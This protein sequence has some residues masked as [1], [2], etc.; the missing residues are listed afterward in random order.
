[1]VPG[2]TWVCS[3]NLGLRP[4]EVRERHL[5]RHPTRTIDRSAHPGQ[6][7]RSRSIRWR[8]VARIINT[9]RFRSI[10]RIKCR[11]SWMLLRRRWRLGLR[12]RGCDVVAAGG[13]DGAV[14]GVS[15]VAA[16]GAGVS[17][18]AAGGW[19]ASY[20]FTAASA[21]PC[22]LDDPASSR[23]RCPSGAWPSPALLDQ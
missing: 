5:I 4:A 1:M 16:G 13:A 22:R 10:K 15:V 19:A 2:R 3:A 9:I 21:P 6:C 18:V 17:V 7:H 8:R 12:C 20:P 23:A 11:L 14:A